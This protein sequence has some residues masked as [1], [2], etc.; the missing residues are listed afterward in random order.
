VT[1]TTAAR[2]SITLR[3]VKQEDEAFLRRVYASSREDELAAVAWTDEQK[4][5]FLRQQFDA[6][7]AHYRHYDPATFDIVEVDGVPVGRL[8]VA[9]WRD[10]I[11]VM[12][13]AILPEHRGAGIGSALLRGVLEEGARS[14]KR[15]SIHVE[16]HNPALGLYERLGF[17]PAADDG[18][19]LRMEASA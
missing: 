14:G 6:Q 9:R 16:K 11:R 2:S 4:G 12:D 3:P 10:E 15:V 13:I 7:S 19:N 17:R 1:W 5:A 18:I 8:Y